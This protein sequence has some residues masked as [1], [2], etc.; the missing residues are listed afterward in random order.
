[1]FKQLNV[2]D[3]YLGAQR[4]TLLITLLWISNWKALMQLAQLHVF[5]E[6]RPIVRGI[7]TLFN[8][9]MTVD[10]FFLSV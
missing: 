2:C 10:V 6:Y 4:I 5:T 8:T 3:Y 9:V 1:M 7:T